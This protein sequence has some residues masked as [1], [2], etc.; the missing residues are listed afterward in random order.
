MVSRTAYRIRAVFKHDLPASVTVFF[1]ALPLC[2]GIALAS[3]AP[4]QAGII[5][6]VIGGILVSLISRSTFS[7]SG[8][9]AGLATIVAAAVAANG[10]YSAF[11]PAVI[12][13]GIFQ[14]TLGVL[15]VGGFVNYFPSSVIKGMLA[16][17]GLLLIGKQVPVAFGIEGVEF[18]S[19]LEEGDFQSIGKRTAAAALFITAVS[20]G[21]LTMLPKYAARFMRLLPPPLVVVLVAIGLAIFLPFLGPQWQLNVSQLVQVPE[22]LVG[23]MIYPDFQK[24]LSSPLVWKTGLIL[25]IVATLES[26]LCVEAIDKLDPHKRTSPVNRELI[27][28]GVGNSVCGFLG[29]VPITAVIVRGSANVQAG[30]QSRASAFLH[31]IFLLAAVMWLPFV[32]NRIPSAALAAILILTGYKLC[33]PAKIRAVYDLGYAQFLPFL[34][35]VILVVAVDLLAG[36]LTGVAVA[37]YFILQKTVRAEYDV[38]KAR[39][40]ESEVYDIRL[41]SNVTFLNK[42]K[43]KRLLDNIPAYSIVRINGFHSHYIDHDVLELIAEY[44]VRA[45]DKHI[46]LELLGVQEIEVAAA[47]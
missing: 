15:R 21:M 1:V 17:I 8:P 25:G 11:L 46:A 3:G 23:N 20:L 32:I 22:N 24:A 2:L 33:H 38:K 43:L 44:R 14:I 29:G 36:V 7:V 40:G 45:H 16:G 13:A 37:C 34:V 9:A 5:S 42:I 30:A 18:W 26:L 12:I 19:E 47:H 10:D 35:T 39:S 6:G 41:H 27:A 31:G 4:P 28:Q